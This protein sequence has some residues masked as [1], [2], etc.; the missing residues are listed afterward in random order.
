[1]KK[2]ILGAISLTVALNAG[3]ASAFSLISGN[4]ITPTTNL[5]SIGSFTIDEIADGI[6]A[7]GLF[8]SFPGPFN[9]FASNASS[10]TITLELNGEFNLNSFILW[11]DI[12]VFEEGIKDFRLD[13]FNDSNGLI[14]S[15]PTFL[16]P[17]TQV[18]P[19]EYVFNNLIL[20]V[21]KVDLVVLNSNQSS[22]GINRIEIREVA[23]TGSPTAK[24]PEPTSMFSAVVAGLGIL[25][26][27]GKSRAN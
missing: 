15:S 10:G 14:A 11:N 2:I 20:G 26:L 23:F 27:K 3:E 21:S 16:A 22:L 5:Q 6:T 25:L 8:P 7:D 4:Q 18:D 17:I 13:F 24:T 19:R 12:N 9:G 1:M